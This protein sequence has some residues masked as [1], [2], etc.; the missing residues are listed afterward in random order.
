MYVAFLGEVCQTAER[1][2]IYLLS[3]ILNSCCTIVVN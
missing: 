2:S 3:I 1:I